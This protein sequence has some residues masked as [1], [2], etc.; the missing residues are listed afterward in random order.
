MIRQAVIDTGPLFSALVVNHVQQRPTKGNRDRLLGC[1]N[2][3][4]QHPDAHVRFL[5]VLGS[6]SRKLTTSHVLGEINGL[7]NVK[8]K[9]HEPELSRFWNGCIELLTLW[10]LDERLIR[11]LDFAGASAPGIARLGIV[12]TGLIRLAQEHG[13]V[14]ITEDGPL[15]RLAGEQGVDCRSLKSLL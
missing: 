14:L 12:D 2:E 9:L 8:L 7:V 4:V 13:C 11:F 6:I 15:F 10:E 1:V 5:S 3:S